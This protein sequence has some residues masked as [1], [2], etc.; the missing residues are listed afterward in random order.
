MAWFVDLGANWANTLNLYEPLRA[1]SRSVWNVVAFEASPLVQPFLRDYCRFLNGERSDEP[2]NCLPRSGSTAHLLRYAP[3][4]GCPASP[5]NVG[6]AC[7]WKCLMPHL[8]ALRPD[9][10]LNSSEFV[11][12]ALRTSLVPAVGRDRYTVVPA[13][14][15]DG[16][17]WMT[18]YENPKQLIRGGALGKNSA[19]L[20]PK[21][22]FAVDVARWLL[23]LPESAYVFLKMDIEGAEHQLLRRMELLGSHRRIS[24]LSIECHGKCKDTMQRVRSWNVTVVGENEH[25]GMDGRARKHIARPIQSRC[26]CGAQRYPK[27]PSGSSP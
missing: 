23:Q 24:R 20:K 1:P 3:K 19:D 10:T 6:R 13:A 5:P 16:E 25:H 14:A 22:I 7:M 8:N 21:R 11:H 2:E 4:Y 18:I 17:G 27:I 12:N 26:K 9:T 15:G